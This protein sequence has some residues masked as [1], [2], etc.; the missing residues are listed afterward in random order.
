MRLQTEVGSMRRAGHLE[1]LS[2]SPNPCGGKR[3]PD[4]SVQSRLERGNKS[5]FRLRLCRIFRR[6]LLNVNVRTV[7][8]QIDDTSN[9]AMLNNPRPRAAN[10]GPADVHLA[11]QPCHRQKQSLVLKKV[12]H[13]ITLLCKSFTSCRVSALCSLRSFRLVEMPKSKS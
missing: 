8:S 7:E 10:G 6:W 9:A 5:Y 3:Q 1:L 4:T 2:T 12:V 13:L 11:S